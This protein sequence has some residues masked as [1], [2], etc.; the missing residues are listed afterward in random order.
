M[1]AALVLPAMATP[2]AAVNTADTHIC[3]ATPMRAAFITVALVTSLLANLV[4]TGKLLHSDDAATRTSTTGEAVVMRTEGGRLEVSTVDQPEVFEASQDHTIL[5][6]PV[7]RT[8]ARIKVPARYRYHIDLAPQWEILLRDGSFIV[9]ASPA[10]PSLPVAIDT[11]R[12]QKE[13][14]GAWSVFTGAAE[15]DALERSITRTLAAKAASPSALTTQ[16]EAAR[17]TVTEFVAAWLVTQ[18]RWQGATSH[19][20][21]VLF[22]DEP[23][24]AL[25]GALPPSRT[26]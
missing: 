8:V 25:S 26:P 16:R 7:G 21:R 17:R 3:E 9:V 19:Q 11:A 2:P 13:S 1:I 5:G 22:A 23:I 20:V 6:V 4:L 15:L 24:D 12:M 10:Q 14:F 18:P